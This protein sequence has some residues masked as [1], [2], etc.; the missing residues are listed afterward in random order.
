MI[1]FENIMPLYQNAHSLSWSSL[2]GLT[3]KKSPEIS[4]RKKWLYE[5]INHGLWSNFLGSNP[6]SVTVNTCLT[7]S[8]HSPFTP[9]G[10]GQSSGTGGRTLV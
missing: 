9:M 7:A 2:H 3:F 4:I 5:Q 1:E 6:I 10:V 8:S